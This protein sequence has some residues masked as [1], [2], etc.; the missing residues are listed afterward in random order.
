MFIKNKAM[1][2][3]DCEKEIKKEVRKEFMTNIFIPA[4]DFFKEHFLEVNRGFSE[5]K[6]GV[7]YDYEYNN[8][9]K[10]KTEKESRKYFGIG[11]S[12][13][14]LAVVSFISPLNLFFYYSSIVFYTKSFSLLNKIKLYD[15]LT[16]DCLSYE[17]EINKEK[18]IAFYCFKNSEKAFEE[19][20][21]KK[22]KEL[23]NEK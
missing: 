10:S 15:S 19:F 2:C 4:K 8:Y 5:R 13:T 18:E 22:E 1:S 12:L 20:Y 7:V 23:T 17:E 6:E 16:K 14:A 11:L 21:Y 3:I 9:L